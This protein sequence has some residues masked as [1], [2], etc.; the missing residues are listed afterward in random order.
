MT[1][2]AIILL[3]HGSRDPLWHRNIESVRSR[4][5]TTSPATLV[6][7]A[8]LELSPPTLAEAMEQVHTA[9]A[10]QAVVLPLFLGMGKHARQDIPELMDGL[11]AAYPHIQI[12]LLASAGE[13]ERLIQLLADMALQGIP[14]GTDSPT[15]L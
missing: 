1:T 13:D 12:D 6:V 7:C 15:P 2:H 14:H 10:T 8:Y 3:A 5:M 4:I 9:G 11:R